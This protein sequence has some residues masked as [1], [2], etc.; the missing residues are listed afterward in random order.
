MMVPIDFY[1]AIR[2]LVVTRVLGT[3]V[4]CALILLLP[5]VL[6]AWLACVFVGSL[7]LGIFQP[8]LF[9]YGATMVVFDE[10]DDDDQDICLLSGGTCCS[11]T[12]NP[13]T[14]AW[15]T[16]QDFWNYHN[17]D[18]FAFLRNMEEARLRPGEKPF[19]IPILKI[20]TG[21]LV[22]AGAALPGIIIN[23]LSGVILVPLAMLIALYE[24]SAHCFNVICF[25]SE[26]DDDCCSD[27]F[28]MFLMLPLVFV[29]WCIFVAILPLYHFVG[30][31]TYMGLTS[32][33]VSICTDS[34]AAGIVAG[35]EELAKSNNM[36]ASFGF[37][38]CCAEWKPFPLCCG[39]YETF[40]TE[41]HLRDNFA[42][43][44]KTKKRP[45][46][47]GP[48]AKAIFHQGLT[49]M[50]EVMKE[51]VMYFNVERN[52]IL[53]N[54]QGLK[55]PEPKAVRK[56]HFVGLEKAYKLVKISHV[57]DAF[58]QQCSEVI[59]ECL[60]KGFL[61]EEQVMGAQSNA[62]TRQPLCANILSAVAVQL[63]V[64]SAACSDLGINDLLMSD[65]TIVNEQNMPKLP[66]SVQNPRPSLLNLKFALALARQKGLVIMCTASSHSVSQGR[67]F[68]P[69]TGAAKI[70][71]PVSDLNHQDHSLNE[72]ENLWP[73]ILRE[74]VTNEN[75]NKISPALLTRLS[76]QI[77]PAEC[78]DAK[79][80]L[81][82]VKYYSRQVL[83][84]STWLPGFR[85][86]FAESARQGVRA[87]KDIYV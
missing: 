54:Q 79:R 71:N 8:L 63:C 20:F 31:P 43:N 75:F 26:D 57:Y 60:R 62:S 37:E 41:H 29:G 64:R 17:D 3:S 68:E 77:S 53:Q 50:T 74:V 58:Y 39:T 49:T 85:R 10:D 59:A 81:R 87:S 55:P 27:P 1:L 19:E 40:V 78:D 69:K 6:C 14:S 80:H 51:D 22:F 13:V 84:A 5:A 70:S 2:S 21:P 52:K 23:L 33:Y 32:A 11:S 12:S 42:S 47:K 72:K 15:E 7:L 73:D 25:D 48:P 24:L 67:T 61:C 82:L 44:T 45:H 38:R 9:A 56:R 66:R 18:C 65:G 83:L 16:L 4:K 76:Q 36:L 35:F 46:S 86:R 28:T 34:M 30:V